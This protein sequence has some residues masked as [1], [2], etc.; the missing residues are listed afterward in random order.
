MGAPRTPPSLDVLLDWFE[1]ALTDCADFLEHKPH[2]F[3]W[4]A[5]RCAE[6]LCVTLALRAGQRHDKLEE[7]SLE[8]LA[9]LVPQK[10][11]GSIKSLRMAGNYGAHVQ[12]LERFDLRMLHTKA[13]EVRNS[14]IV[15]TDWF[16]AEALVRSVPER[17]A[18]AARADPG[19]RVG[20][21]PL[22]VARVRSWPRSSVRRRPGRSARALSPRA[23][24]LRDATNPPR[25]NGH[26][27]HEDRRVHNLGF[28]C[29]HPR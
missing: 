8:N 12:P 4:S 10:H 13:D 3:L 23:P 28:R 17:V 27:F 6:A 16:Y 21:R 7:Q 11:F 20:R 14:L 5:R 22:P 9:Q 15:S 18:R 2:A 24:E 1:H 25:Y 29:A 19:V 26:L